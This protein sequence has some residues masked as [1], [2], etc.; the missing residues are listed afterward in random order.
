MLSALRTVEQNR[1]LFGLTSGPAA[2][3]AAITGFGSDAQRA[4]DTEAALGSI[5]T[6][7]SSLIKGIP[8]NF[9]VQTFFGRIPNL[10]GLFSLESEQKALSKLANLKDETQF[11]V[12][13]AIAYYK[14]NKNSI[15]SEFEEIAKVY[16][17][18]IGSVK[19]EEYT[20]N[21]QEAFDKKFNVYTKEQ[22]DLI[23]KTMEA[24]K[25]QGMSRELA[26]RFLKSRNRLQ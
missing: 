20:P 4:A 26:I 3:A 19:P 22:E 17:I 14:K 16:G 1:D 6:N 2:R 12:R 23:N 5:K 8:S 11:L 13:S 21:L 25:N 9:D 7:V 15:P 24:N 10:N 18:D